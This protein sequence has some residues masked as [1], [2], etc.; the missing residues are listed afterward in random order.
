M[1][2][3]LIDGIA[4]DREDWLAERSKG[5]GASEIAAVLGIS[6]Y[7]DDTPLNLY[8]RKIG[9]IP[10]KEETEPMW[11]G[12]EMEPLI[13]KRYRMETGCEFIAEQL[14]IRHPEYPWMI[15]T[16][17]RITD[18]GRIVELKT[19][20][21][22]GA[23]LLGL[24]GTD[25]VPAPWIIQTQQQLMVAEANLSTIK[26]DAADIAAVV[27]GQETRFFTV[28]RDERLCRQIIAR[29]SEFW[30]RVEERRPP[31][32]KPGKDGRLLVYLYPDASG[33]IEATPT[34]QAM[35]DAWEDLGTE[36]GEKKREHETLRDE[37]LR[38]MEME[39]AEY[40]VLMD[41]RRLKRIVTKLPERTQTLRPVTYSQIRVVKA[42][43]S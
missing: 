14:F 34:I 12:T 1:S 16:V 28:R 26:G 22:R 20:G 25:E 4:V 30:K 36:L 35:A 24:D 9:A 11:W 3:V 6:P 19:I 32:P 5:I 2:T 42:R 15:A 41:G 40:A 27:G 39:G 33:E 7:D 29:G 18:E 21:Q 13:A 38:L 43:E 8:L 31:E 17:D 37:L 10:P 23:G